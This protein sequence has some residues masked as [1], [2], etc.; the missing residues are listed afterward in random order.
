MVD[1]AAARRLT[2][3]T[4]SAMNEN[5]QAGRAE[6]LRRSMLSMMDD[7]E[8]AHPAMWAPFVLVGQNRPAE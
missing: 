5:P 7:P 8:F 1:D 2:T 4:L 3:G 6:A